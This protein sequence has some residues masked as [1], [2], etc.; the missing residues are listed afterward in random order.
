MDHEEFQY[1]RVGEDGSG[2]YSRLLAND[3]VEL[4]RGDPT[5]TYATKNHP[6]KDQIINELLQ[7]KYTWGDTF[8]ATLFGSRDGSIPIELHEVEE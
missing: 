8:F 2:W 3:T 7:E 6:D 5:K 1:L 4:T